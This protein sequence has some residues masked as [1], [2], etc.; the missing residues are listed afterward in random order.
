LLGEAQPKNALVTPTHKS[1]SYFKVIIY[2]SLSNTHAYTHNLILSLLCVL[3]A[4][5][6]LLCGT[7]SI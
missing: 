4:A 1:G 5:H 2:V 3:Y 7:K 6:S